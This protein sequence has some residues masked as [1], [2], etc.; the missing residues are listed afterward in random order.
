MSGLGGLIDLV[1]TIRISVP[2]PISMATTIRQVLGWLSNSRP[3][4]MRTIGLAEEA[5][6]CCGNRI[7][8]AA[9]VGQPAEV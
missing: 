4:F 6:F 8:M 2:A 3:D 7:R 9:G 5:A 1:D